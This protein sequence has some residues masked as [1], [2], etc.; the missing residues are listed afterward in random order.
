MDARARHAD[1]LA[2]QGG[3]VI[4][5][6]SSTLHRQPSGAL[7]VLVG[8]VGRFLSLLGDRRRRQNCV[9]P[10]DIQDGDQ[11]A[12]FLP[13]PLALDLHFYTQRIVDIVIAAGDF[14]RWTWKRCAERRFYADF[15]RSFRS[16]DCL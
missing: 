9:H 10:L 4:P 1:T 15:Q 7:V 14:R 2:T 13:D 11:A 3:E 6:L 12:V 8:K 16:V 5:N